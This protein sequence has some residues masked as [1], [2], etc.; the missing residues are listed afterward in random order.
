[1]SGPSSPRRLWWL[2]VVFV[3]CYFSIFAFFPSLFLFVGVNL[4]GVWFLDSYAI[5]ATN[6]A[7]SFGV[8]PYGTNPFDPFGRPHVY[9][10]WWLHLRDLGLTRADNFMVGASLVLAFFVAAIARLRPRSPGELAWY[11]AIFCS[12]PLLLALN[13]ANNDLLIF[14]LLAPVVPCLLSP[15]RSWRLVPVLLIALATGL[16]FYPAVAGLV[17]LAGADKREVRGR[18]VFGLLALALVGVSLAHDLGRRGALTPRAEGIMTFGAVNLLEALGLSGWS[19][20]VAAIVIAG[21]IFVGFWRSRL[22]DEWTMADDSRDAWLSFTLGAVLLTG[23][24]FTGSNYAYRWIFSLWLAPLLWQLLRDPLAPLA[25]RRLAR[26]TMI[27]LLLT[28][29]I[30]PMTSV[31]LGNFQGRVDAPTIMRWAD[32]VFLWEQPITWALF[33][34]LLGFLACFTRGGLR[35]MLGRG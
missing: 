3:G 5:L 1:M 32:R 30:D 7:I 23:C 31:V 13:R 2:M 12:S 34:C 20:A 6:D 17:L 14:V 8:D 9:T 10:H 22:F 25:V 27:L 35:V 11:L 19:V 24:F 29:W 15:L 18:V 16:K 4:F 28:L 26:V 21:A 33:A